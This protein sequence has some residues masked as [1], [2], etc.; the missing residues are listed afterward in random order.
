MKNRPE[1]KAGFAIG[2]PITSPGFQVGDHACV[3]GSQP[4]ML[5]IFRQVAESVSF[6][7]SAG[8]SCLAV[9]SCGWA[10]DKHSLRE[11]RD[12]RR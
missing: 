4:P 10:V 2:S 1:E 6:A 9:P 3:I 12:S 5:S 8:R 11:E 7:V